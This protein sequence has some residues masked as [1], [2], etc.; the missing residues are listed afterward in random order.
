MSE[1]WY[2]TGE[3]DEEDDENLFLPRDKEEARG[4]NDWISQAQEQADK[5]W[6]D[7]DEDEEDE[8]DEGGLFSRLGKP[9]PEAEEGE[10][11]EQQPLGPKGAEQSAEEGETADA[12]EE[13]GVD[14]PAEDE[15]IEAGESE[16]PSLDETE[17]SF[18]DTEPGEGEG[19]GE[20]DKAEQTAPEIPS[21]PEPVEE[22]ASGEAGEEGTPEAE[23]VVSPEAEQLTEPVEED[24][25]SELPESGDEPAE[26]QEDSPPPA[27]EI[28]DEAD[29][30]PADK[31]GE[32]AGDGDIEDSSSGPEP[33][34]VEIPLARKQDRDDIEADSVEAVEQPEAEEV[35]ESPEKGE[36]AAEEEV[37]EEPEEEPAEIDETEDMAALKEEQDAQRKALDEVRQRLDGH[38]KDK[39]KSKDGSNIE[40][41]MIDTDTMNMGLLVHYLSKRRDRKLGSEI[42]KTN[43]ELEKIKSEGQDST[44]SELHQAE[45]SQEQYSD[46]E[47]EGEQIENSDHIEEGEQIEAGEKTELQPAYSE[48]VPTQETEEKVAE[49][50]G[51]I[52]DQET[53]EDE[54]LVQANQELS[55]SSEKNSNMEQEEV[56][57]ETLVKQTET[58]QHRP[59]E[60]FDKRQE[61]VAQP[62]DDKTVVGTGSEYPEQSAT[63]ISDIL[64]N[65][66]DYASE[67]SEGDR[68]LSSE[69]REQEAGHEKYARDYKSSVQA[70]AVAGL[71]IITLLILYLIFR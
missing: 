51:Y 71:I 54:H 66:G 56:E 16:P 70:G 3:D 18:R 35:Y 30:H 63:P 67:L 69:D 68:N 10:G 55:G 14:A 1:K 47:G 50:L 22:T 60:S 49:E 29:E 58:P 36:P 17:V 11:E 32:A 39:E 27:E 20:E 12:E 9:E 41:Y 2:P 53:P 65:R 44:A 26:I 37:P 48:A 42:E 61:K 34:E 13:I 52:S 43:K 31:L 59:E 25:G 21:E 15:A 33:E 8:E 40:D 38:Y 7:S 64:A 57:V 46:E 45:L 23:T 28:E 24:V 6:E 4:L 5:S 19:A 62:K